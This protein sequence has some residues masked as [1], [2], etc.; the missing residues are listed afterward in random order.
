VETIYDWVTIALFA[1]LIVLFLQRSTADE[2]SDR[3]IE[4]LPPAIGCALGNYLGNH[5]QHIL[6]V[7]VIAAVPVYTWFVLKPFAR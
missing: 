4:Y 3:M 2:P 7:L 5:D 1:G 6:A